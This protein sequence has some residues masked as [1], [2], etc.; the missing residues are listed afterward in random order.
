MEAS[1]AAAAAA[2]AAARRR[3]HSPHRNANG[4]QYIPRQQSKAC[5]GSAGGRSS[6]GG[7]HLII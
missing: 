1:A 2:A 5:R 4:T 6:D 3:D 7:R